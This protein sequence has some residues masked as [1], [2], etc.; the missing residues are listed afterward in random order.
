MKITC[1]ASFNY[2]TFVLMLLLPVISVWTQDLMPSSFEVIRAKSMFSHSGVVFPVQAYPISIE[3]LADQLIAL[4]NTFQIADP[5]RANGIRSLVNEFKGSNSGISLDVSG[6]TTFDYRYTSQEI[7]I[8]SGTYKDGIDFYKYYLD[9][10]PFMLLDLSMGGTRGF[11]VLATAELRREWKEDWFKADN[12]FDSLTAGNPL[13]FD[14]NFISRGILRWI[15][16]SS[17]FSLG[18]SKVHYGP[19]VGGT[20]YPSERLPYM[21]ALRS[22]I[23][24]GPLS[25]NWFVST[26]QARRARKNSADVDP[27]EGFGFETDDEAGS[28]PTIILSAM[29]RFAWDFGKFETG[30][31]GL[32]IVSRRNN[33]FQLTDLF[34]VISWHNADVRQNNMLLLADLSWVPIG[35]LVVNAVAGLDD[36]SAEAVGISD[37][38][39]PTIYAWVIGIEAFP[40]SSKGFMSVRAEAGYTHYLWGNYDGAATMQLD[41]NPLSRAI[42]RYLRDGGS[43]LMPLTSPYGPGAAWVTAGLDYKA[44]ASWFK[45]GF[46][47]T[48]LLKNSLASLVGT[49]YQDSSIIAD[50]PQIFFAS[51]RPDVEVKKGSFSVLFAPNLLV[52]DGRWW[53][54]LELISSYEFKTAHVLAVR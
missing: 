31:A 46:K 8:E 11:S 38:G 6:S 13:A 21:D 51:I 7:L 24:L 41:I 43:V 36:F 45:L 49:T 44:Q 26:I 12:L 34:P 28:T 19:A 5:I 30:I 4:A 15:G 54:E 29:H 27:G 9:V 17:V 3:E 50:A 20:L 16:D 35:G 22:D 42:F 52:Q 25:M 32:Q 48:F 33:Y 47:S 53:V 18:R 2:F 40:V 23:N 37:S 39:I 14:N 1:N 10:P